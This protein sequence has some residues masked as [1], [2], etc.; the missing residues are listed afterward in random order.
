MKSI[1]TRN[2]KKTFER[3]MIIDGEP[4]KMIV[5]IRYDDK[6]NNGHN[7]FAITANLYDRGYIRNEAFVTLSTGKKRWLGSCGCLHDHIA[8]Y[9]P[10]LQKY[11][12]WHLCEGVEPMYYIENSLYWLGLRNAPKADFENFKS[13]AIWPEAPLIALEWDEKTATAK[14]NER[15]P[16]LMK[17]FRAA[18]KELGFVY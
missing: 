5:T 11:I 17:D 2:Q 16:A 7:S 15:L 12:K 18:V 6:C 4:C 10:E 1:L 14:L 8:K 3:E 13:T 9:F